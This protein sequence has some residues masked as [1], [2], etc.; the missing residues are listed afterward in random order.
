MLTANLL[1]KILYPVLFLS[2]IGAGGCF[3]GT[4]PAYTVPELAHHFLLSR[5]RFVV[6]EPD[7]V[8]RVRAAATQCGIPESRIFVLHQD[9]DPDNTGVRSWTEL[10]KFGEVPWLALKGEDKARETSAALLSTSGTTGL[11]K[12]AIRSHD[13]FIQEG[14]AMSDSSNK[15]YPVSFAPGST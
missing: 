14:L 10:L 12:L 13:G 15:P 8:D 3:T 7:R 9:D 6:T 4:N 2:I 1:G 5:A 11:P